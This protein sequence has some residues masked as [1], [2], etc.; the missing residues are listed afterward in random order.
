[1]KK[2][3]AIAILAL[4]L[5]TI[6]FAAMDPILQEC[7]QRGY[8]TEY[9]T[10]GLTGYCVLPDKSKCILDDFNNGTCGAQYKNEDYCV[11]E[12]HLVWGTSKCC[13]GTEAYLKPNHI[14]QPSC[15]RISAVQKII[16]QIKYNPLVWF[17]GVGTIFIFVIFFIIL[18][19]RKR[20]N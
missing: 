1:M 11:S 10:D 19:T 18:K 15:L 20:N 13:T 8:E 5:P 2:I 12:G 4:T 6:T 9:S 14:G 17:G 3:I 7:V 16:N